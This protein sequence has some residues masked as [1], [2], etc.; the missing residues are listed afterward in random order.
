M[1]PASGALFRFCLYNAYVIR[2]RLPGVLRRL[3]LLAD[4]SDVAGLLRVQRLENRSKSHGTPLLLRLPEQGV[5]PAQQRGGELRLQ[6]RRLLGKETVVQ[7]EK[8][9]NSLLRPGGAEVFISQRALPGL[10]LRGRV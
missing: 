8:P 3:R 7:Q 9:Q 4:G 2:Q 5:N 10:Y 6:K 1:V